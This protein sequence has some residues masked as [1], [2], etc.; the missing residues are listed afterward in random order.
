MSIS[1]A[2]FSYFVSLTQNIKENITQML[3]D[4]TSRLLMEMSRDRMIQHEDAAW[5]APLSD[6]LTSLLNK[7]E[8]RRSA[9]TLLVNI[10]LYRNSLTDLCH[11]IKSVENQQPSSWL[12][13]PSSL[14]QINRDSS[15]S[16][17][18]CADDH[19]TG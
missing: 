13:E 10:S 15:V 11:V 3:I 7:A 5:S 12:F 6:W 9:A 16:R 19:V 17:K 1:H 4:D 8:F 14:V 18:T 2:L